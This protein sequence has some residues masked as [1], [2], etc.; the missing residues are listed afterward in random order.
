MGGISKAGLEEKVKVNTRVET[1]AGITTFLTMA[2]I[3]FVNPIIVGSGFE[4]ALKNALGTQN[5]TDDQIAL[6]NSVKIGIATA[7]M[8]AAAFG[9][10]LMGLL[11]R[12]PLGLAPGMGENSFIAFTVIPAF[13]STLLTLGIKL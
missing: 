7:T 12:L 2:Y 13:T 6:V 9:S 1:I 5:L 11:A 3:I 4:I 10:I 8:I